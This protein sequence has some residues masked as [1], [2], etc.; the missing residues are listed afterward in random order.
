M[1]SS[2]TRSRFA[3]SVRRWRTRRGFSQEQL[4][5]RANLHR[6]YIS[7]VE[8][9]ARNLSLESINRLATALEIS[10]P[11]LFS[12]PEEAPAPPPPGGS[13]SLPGASFVNVL[14]V[15]D[16]PDDVTLTLEAFKRARFVN[17]VHVARDGAEAVERLFGKN[18]IA[19]E[20]AA[21]R[22]WMVLL[23]LDLPR[24]KGMEILRRLK[25][26]AR[27]AAIPVVLLTVS[28]NAQDIAAGRKLG[29]TAYITKPVNLPGLSQV[30]PDLC[31]VWALINPGICTQIS[32]S[33][34]G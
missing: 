29:A 34:S 32:G 15:E 17:T 21:G 31:L 7:D 9:G 12:G 30:T 5:E 23:D 19:E 25:A 10:V 13:K 22:N 3:S 24:V 11:I 4:A 26:D 28:D 16:N 8:R 14:L 18:G 6:T 33:P 27:T 1:E 2:D 20:P